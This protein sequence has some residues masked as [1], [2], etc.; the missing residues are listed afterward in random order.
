MSKEWTNEKKTQLVLSILA[1]EKT[2]TQAAIEYKLDPIEIEGWRDLYVSGLRHAA[3]TSKPSIIRR[4][5]KTMARHPLGATSIGLVFVLVLLILKP[6]QVATTMK[7]QIQ[8]F[9]SLEPVNQLLPTK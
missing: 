5:N 1:G 9:V 3:K 7:Y 2:I 4:F 8:N 6:Q